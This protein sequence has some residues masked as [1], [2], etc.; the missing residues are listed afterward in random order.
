MRVSEEHIHLY[1]QGGNGT[2]PVHA[3]RIADTR[4]RV[5]SSPGFVLGVAAGDEIELLTSDGQFR[6]LRHGGNV[7]VQFYSKESVQGYREW[8]AAQVVEKLNGILDGSI[9][10]GLV[11]TIPVGT[12]FE[13][14]ESFFDSLVRGLPGTQWIY[15]NVYDPDTGAPL[16][17]W[18]PSK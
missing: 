18:R 5:L 9:D 16:E 4:Y 15:G 2:E 10:R 3:M 7:A 12:G 17:W 8:V 1:V 11:F 13:K 14:I 6:V